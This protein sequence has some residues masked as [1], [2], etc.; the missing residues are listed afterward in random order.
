MR[1]GLLRRIDGGEWR[2]EEHISYQLITTIVDYCYF[3][4]DGPHYSY[5]LCYII[6]TLVAC[7]LCCAEM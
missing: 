7:L 4:A 6:V 2:E 5:G 3:T 1:C